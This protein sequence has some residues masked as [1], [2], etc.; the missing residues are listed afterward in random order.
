MF[1]SFAAMGAKVVGIP[2][3]ADGPD[4]AQAG[5]TGGAAQAAPVR[6]QLGAAQPDLD[7][8]VGGQGLPGAAHR[9]EHDITIV[10]DD[11]YCDLHAGQYRPPEQPATRLAALDQLRRVIYLGGFSKS[12]AAN[13]RVGFIATSPDLARAWPT[14]RCCR[15]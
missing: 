2:R 10:E 13:L 14:A 5:R 1:G 9:R 15:R 8:A 7:F 6:H 11:I 12:L 4:I 3:L